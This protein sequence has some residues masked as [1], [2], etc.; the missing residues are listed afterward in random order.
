MSSLLRRF[1]NTHRDQL[2]MRL[3]TLAGIA[4]AP[5]LAWLMYRP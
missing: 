4:L 2:T 1:W 3:V 5:L